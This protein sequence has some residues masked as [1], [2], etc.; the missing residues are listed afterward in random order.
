[1]DGASLG[2]FL[3][4]MFGSAFILASTP[5]EIFAIDLHSH[6]THSRILPCRLSADSVVE[7]DAYAEVVNPPPM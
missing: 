2:A 4:P 7:N 6:T 5:D 1:M 3:G